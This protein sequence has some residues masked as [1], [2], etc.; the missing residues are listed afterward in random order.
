MWSASKIG[1]MAA[2]AAIRGYQLT[3][4]S[5]AGSQCRHLPTC[6]AYMNE[7]IAR[8][9]LWAG[10]FMGAARLCRCHPLGT[11]GFDPVPVDPPA[12]ANWLRPWRYG[13]WR[14]PLPEPASADAR[15]DGG[16]DEN[17]DS[18]EVVNADDRP[19]AAR[20]G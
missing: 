8:H 16:A 4:S 7:A 3:F 18:L 13:R 11:A 17:N 6:S 9:G 12:D 5:L 2:R 1:R 19:A 15:G 20:R 14:G 10:G